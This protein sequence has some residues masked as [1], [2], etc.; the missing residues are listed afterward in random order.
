MTAKM[1]KMDDVNIKNDEEDDGEDVGD[2][3]EDDEG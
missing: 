1:K 2:E 3:A